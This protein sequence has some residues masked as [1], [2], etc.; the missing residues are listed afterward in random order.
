MP[1]IILGVRNTALN[2]TGIVPALM[3][4]HVPVRGER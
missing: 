1:G 3:E 4:L 2:K